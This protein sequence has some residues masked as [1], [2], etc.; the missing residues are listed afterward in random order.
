MKKIIYVISLVLLVACS[1]RSNEDKALELIE[2]RLKAILNNPKSYEFISIR[3][4]SCYSNSQMNPEMFVFAT[5]ISKLWKDYKEFSTEAETAESFMTIYAPSNGYQDAHTKQ[6]YK[7]YK[8]DLDKSNKKKDAAKAKILQLY[9]D[10]KQLLINIFQNND[11]KGDFIGW[12]SN[13]RFRCENNAGMKR[14][15][16]SFY[17]FDKSLETITHIFHQDDLEVLQQKDLE[18]I[19]YEFEKELKDMFQLE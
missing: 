1:A 15:L 11:T 18:D 2:P 9:K 13:I 10:N 14:T 19:Q 6:Q 16:E 3:L 12:V 8:T 5:E 4:D 7:K 17:F